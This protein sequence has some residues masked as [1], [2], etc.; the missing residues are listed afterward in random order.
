MTPRAE[1]KK[2]CLALP[3]ATEERTGRH[4]AYLV[5]NKKFAYYL[6]DH[7]GDGR[8]AVTTRAAPGENTALIASNPDRYFFMPSYIGPRGWVGLYLDL[9]RVDW[10]EVDELVIDSYLLVAPKRLAALVDI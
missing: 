6:D 1:V 9:G 4:A 7:H 10:D 2:I 3:E 8:V 5:R